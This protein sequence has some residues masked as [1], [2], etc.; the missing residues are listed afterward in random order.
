VLRIQEFE[1]NAVRTL[2][3]G[4]RMRA[5]LGAALIHNPSV[6]YLDEPTIGLDVVVKDKI[7][8]AIKEMN[9][10]FQTTVILTTHD[11]VDI[12]ELC[13]HII[14]IDEGSK[15]YDG[16]LERLKSNYG[17]KTM[18]ELDISNEEQL[19]ELNINKA[20]SLNKEELSTQIKGH[21][22]CISFVKDKIGVSKLAGYVM[23]LCDVTDMRIKETDITTI[24]KKIY[25]NGGY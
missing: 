14:I 9:R 2:S 6:L 5:D 25:T 24:V 22:L 17:Q 21:T 18:L 8:D 11:L 12:E 15:I 13:Q 16:T 19:K 7:R 20:F 3:L 23:N 1:N 10:N 4:Q